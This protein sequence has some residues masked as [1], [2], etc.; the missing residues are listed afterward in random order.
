[1]LGLVLLVL[2]IVAFIMILLGIV[3]IMISMFKEIENSQSEGKRVEGGGVIII[4]PLPIVVGTSERV[5]RVLLIMAMLLFIVVVATYIFL[6][7]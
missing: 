7:R 2:F 5:T 1:M 3:L 6:L 4:G